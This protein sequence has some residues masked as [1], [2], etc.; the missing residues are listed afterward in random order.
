[1]NI[2]YLIYGCIGLGILILSSNYIDVSYIVSKLFF[3]KKE[4]V[5]IPVKNSK[6]EDFLQIVGLWFQL[7]EKCEQ[8]DLEVAC[9][10]LDEV[11]PLLNGVLE[12]E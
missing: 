7:K 3:S 9:N 1:M 4:N 6:Q 2:D 12:D 8:F 5:V 10:K 11:F